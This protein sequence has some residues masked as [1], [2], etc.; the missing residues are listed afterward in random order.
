MWEKLNNSSLLF[1]RSYIENKKNL[2][3]YSNRVFFNRI[4]FYYIN[5][6][7]YN[8]IIN[9]VI[10]LLV[11]NFLVFFLIFLKNCVNYN[12]LLN[13]KENT[14]IMEYIQ[15]N[16]FFD[17]LNLF[18]IGL[19]ILFLFLD[20]V[21]I[22]SLVDDIYIYYNIKIFYN[23]SLKIKDADL[24]YLEWS[25]ILSIYQDL[26]NNNIN[27]FYINSI[28]TSKDN[29]F[30]A[31]LEQHILRP[32]H[33]NS[34]LEWNLKYCIIYSIINKNEHIIEDVKSNT[35]KISNAIKFKLRFIAILNLVFMPLIIVI[36]IFY[37]LFNYGELFY[38]KPGMLISSN[39]SKIATWEFRNYNELEHLFTKRITKIEEY[40][41]K[42]SNSFKN[43]ILN[44]IL[45]FI[46]FV[47]SA[48]FI[49]LLILTVIND[50]ILT[51]LNIIGNKNVLWFLG[52]I[53][54]IIAL[55][56]A[57][58]N[59]KNCES[60]NDIMERISHY[61][62][63]DKKIIRNANTY[64]IKNKFLEK[65]SFK[66]VQIFLDILFTLLMPIQLW[67]ISYDSYYIS[68]FLS[69]ITNNNKKIGLTCKYADFENNPLDFF[70]S[71]IT[72]TEKNKI[73]KKI[74]F[75]EELFTQEFS[76]W[77]EFSN[78]VSTEINVL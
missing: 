60:P 12:G 75:S 56:R 31:L 69:K 47:L 9:S 46:I 7:Y 36:I 52:V 18:I 55:L 14:H 63:V 25:N 62:I 48:F 19:L 17:E 57:I 4:Y 28:I 16:H 45:S 29:Y 38:N 35:N 20:I 39:F 6:G 13:T 23:N 11:S 54:S 44:A 74:N 58:L 50:N 10:N 3:I 33:L 64:L 61:I 43:K 53:G 77:I 41:K 42:Y 1:N 30:I 78:N 51:N 67:S 8:I 24:E 66:I 73:I 72:D 37:N 5:K 22:I 32:I 71:L 68:T 59:Q 49:T 15:F 27:P 21:K 76:Q 2:N 70:G 34:I 26:E 65:Y 40:T